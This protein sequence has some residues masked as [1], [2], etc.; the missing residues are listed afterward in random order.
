M[1]VMLISPFSWADY[2][3]SYS[4]SGDGKSSDSPL[5]IVTAGDLRTLRN[6]VNNGS[7]TSGRYYILSR[8]IN[9]T[10]SEWEA[11]GN[12]YTGNAFTGHF[13]GN[14]KTIHVQIRQLTD[15][16]RDDWYYQDRALFGC[17]NT[18]D[19]AVKNLRVGGYAYGYNAAGL[20]SCLM[21]GIIEYC[22]VSADIHA[23]RN[24]DT[25]EEDLPSKI[26]AGG[27]AAIMTG[28]T[29]D[30]CDFSG[31]IYANTD[32]E[33]FKAFSG[34][35]AGNV[36][37]TGKIS[38]CSVKHY[39]S[40]TSTGVDTISESSAEE[41]S[42]HDSAGG[43]AGYVNVEDVYFDDD[44]DTITGCNFEG[45][46]ITSTYYAGGIAGYSRGGQY[47]YNSVAY[48][49]RITGTVTAGGI[50]GSLGS[51]GYVYSND[52]G[53]CIVSAASRAAGGIVGL[54]ELGYVDTNISTAAIR[55]DAPY[56]G[57]VIGEIH[58][59]YGT[60]TNVTNNEYKGADYGIGRDEHEYLNMDTGCTKLADTLLYF[61]TPSTL[62]EANENELYTATIELSQSA[63]LD[64][65]P[66]P[67][68]MKPVQDGEI[69]KINGVP[70]T[71]GTT[72]F[73]LSVNYGYQTIKR[74]FYITVNS[75][76]E[77]S[78]VYDM[79]VSVDDYIEIEPVIS[80]RNFDIS[81]ASFDWSV[82]SGELPYN[83]SIE[84]KTG[85]I[86]GYV[87]EAGTFNFFIQAEPENVSLNS[88]AKE[89]TLY[90]DTSLIISADDALPYAII[91]EDYNYKFIA[92]G[93]SE[94]LI[95]WSADEN[96]P[97]G[98]TMYS[99]GLLTGIPTD[100]GPHTFTVYASAGGITVSKIVTLNVLSSITI[101]TISAD[102]V[103]PYAVIDEAYN[104]KF[105]ATG[106][107][108]DSIKWS[109]DENIP[110]GLTMYSSGL[111]TGTPEDVGSYTFTV[112]AEA[113]GITVSKI[114]T[115]NVLSS[116][117]ILTIS[118]DNVLPYAVIY[119]DYNY[120][121]TATGI[122]EDLIT[123]SI[124]ENIPSGLTMYSNG[125]LTGMPIDSGPHTF[126][127]YAEAGGITVSKRVTLNVLSS[128]TILT[129]SPLPNAYTGRN[130]QLSLSH[131]VPSGGSMKWEIISG[132][133]PSGF[134][135]DSQTGIIS[136]VTNVVKVYDFTVQ[137]TAILTTSKDFRLP[138]VYADSGTASDDAGSVSILTSSLPSGVLG[139]EYYAVLES[140]PSGASW[141]QNG[142]IIPPGLTLSSNGTIS[143]I[144]SVAG[145][146]S[147]YAA[148]SATSY[149]SSN[150]QYS[151]TIAQSSGE[152]GEGGIKTKSSGGGGGCY[153]VSGVVPLILSFI[154]IVSKKK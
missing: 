98:L 103:I 113:G 95:T 75:Q 67:S 31:K 130:Y 125:L 58:N 81:H 43:I 66:I 116:I 134:T 143:G 25:E 11:I 152:D 85:K 79:T 141:S 139:Q 4:G 19:Y 117:M 50:I 97:S 44:E 57:G 77:I 133:L 3:P 12:Q 35:I 153:S 22:T 64:L 69:I 53:D 144:P 39:A 102:D 27:I 68:W 115:L 148:A 5:W 150:R 2:S 45:G 120:K 89:M 154:F 137:L 46:E 41:E 135:L 34:G 127:V 17:I 138:V 146:F 38:N 94:D 87:R 26:N 99:N 47:T 83:L 128:I 56:R 36:T 86:S 1:F 80:S 6:S 62:P 30:N 15:A 142:G 70:T 118:A 8:D 32:D 109:T 23:F 101:F 92:T 114:V 111:L 54:L 14:N 72:S 136:G 124:D 88:V 59:H 105:T 29:V 37:G 90:V 51:G 52:V 82:V 24:G 132:D 108:E 73:T 112:Y 131:D 49:T 65:S 104:Y 110:S 13:D 119:K 121:F 106:I 21:S 78:N 76:L 123:W 28:G 93:I 74:T 91:Y 151:V 60:S 55:G 129:S 40:I 9:I 147:F 42:P 149:K 7:E 107:S 16:D 100:S 96:I 63:I 20:V 61:I 122:S 18:D 145:T 48:D 33:L 84:S 71:T 126:T 10:E 140:F